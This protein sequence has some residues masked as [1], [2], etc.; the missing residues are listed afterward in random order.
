ML[1][2][3]IARIQQR[4][5]NPIEEYDFEGKHV[6][7]KDLS[8]A[9]YFIEMSVGTPAQTFEVVPHTAHSNVWVYGSG[10]ELSS[11]IACLGKHLYKEKK[12]STFHKDGEEFDVNFGTNELKGKVAQDIV[13]VGDVK[14][15][16]K[17]GELT[18]VKRNVFLDSKAT[19]VL[20]LAY[21]PLSIDN[22]STFWDNADSQDKSFSLYLHSNPDES[23]MVIPGMDDTNWGVIDT[24]KV[25]EQKYWNLGLDYL[26]QGSG[27]YIQPMGQTVILD[28]STSLIVGDKDTMAKLFDGVEVKS[29]CSNIDSLPSVTFGIDG[30]AYTLDAYDYVIKTTS[31]KAT[32]CSAGWGHYKQEN[33]PMSKYITLGD[34]FLRKYPTHFDFN[35][36]TV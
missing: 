23:Y 7:M 12:S 8:D 28:S 21:D 22:L 5:E 35:N 1:D 10:C 26:Q 9:Q 13:Q 36:N 25:L 3:Q 18:K 20:G 31:K 17:F 32:V 27:A 16:M 6:V 14:S 34:V 11:P 29:D 24:H 19:G 33:D 30:V 4:S 2:S 15:T